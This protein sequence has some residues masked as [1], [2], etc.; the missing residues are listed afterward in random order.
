MNVEELRS[1]GLYVETPTMSRAI[2]FWDHDPTDAE[3]VEA[4]KGFPELTSMR[5]YVILSEKKLVREVHN[6]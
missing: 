3:I 1:W 6:T 5:Y 2:Q 4:K